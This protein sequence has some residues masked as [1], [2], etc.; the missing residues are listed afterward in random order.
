MATTKPAKKA[1]A[2]KKPTKESARPLPVSLAP[3]KLDAA[4]GA[5]LAVKPTAKTKR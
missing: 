1:K 4:M 2:V 3:L 5:L